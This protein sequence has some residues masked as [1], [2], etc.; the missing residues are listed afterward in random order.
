M[1]NNNNEQ[2]ESGTERPGLDRTPPPQ[3]PG[4]EQGASATPR[5]PT[6]GEQKAPPPQ[7][8]PEGKEQ[9]APP[10]VIRPVKGER[11]PPAWVEGPLGSRQLQLSWLW[12]NIFYIAVTLLV[13]ILITAT[14]QSNLRKRLIAEGIGTGGVVSTEGYVPIKVF[15]PSSGGLVPEERLVPP[16]EVQTRVVESAVLEYLKGP[17][18]DAVSYVPEGTQLLGLYRG[19]DDIIYMDLSHEFRSNFQGDAYGEFLL[20]RGLY[21]SVM[22][23]A[24]DV[25][26][27]KVLIEG[28]D[29]DTIGGHISLKGTLGSVV[30]STMIEGYEDK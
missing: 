23:N 27:L 8:T 6:G 19:S 14:Y 5:R 9:K 2:N 17:S 4:G 11:R 25:T 30:S 28:K 7:D 29:V 20:L 13:C 21:E 26:G 15:Y 12:L 16:S 3:Q 24:E 1:M 18:G 10:A 22:S